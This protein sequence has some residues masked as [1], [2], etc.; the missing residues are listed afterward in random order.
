MAPAGKDPIPG[1]FGVFEMCN[2]HLLPE[3]LLIEQL[4]YSFPLHLVNTSQPELVELFS[5][6]ISP[7]EQ[8]V[9]RD[10]RRGI[11]LKRLQRSPTKKSSTET[12]KHHTLKGNDDKCNFTKPFTTGQKEKRASNDSDGP[13]NKRSKI[14]W[15]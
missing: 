8:R 4:T 15:P 2:P 10:N 13:D 5:I 7:K 14:T 1:S 12:Q 3:E 11:V 9:H 6:H